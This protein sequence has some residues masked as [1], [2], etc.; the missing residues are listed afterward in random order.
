MKCC[1]NSDEVYETTV[2][3][4][5]TRSFYEVDFRRA[6]KQILQAIDAQ[7]SVNKQMLE[8]VIEKQ[9]QDDFRSAE[10]QLNDFINKFQ[11]DFDHILREKEQKEA[12]APEIINSLKAEKER[13]SKYLKDLQDVRDFLNSWKQS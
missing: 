11:S 1:C 3:I 4:K 7:V 9:I 8:R 6:S 10:N 2:P 13:L 5:E 12:Q